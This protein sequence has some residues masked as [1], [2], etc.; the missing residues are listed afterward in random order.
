MKTE[1][2]YKNMTAH[3]ESAYLSCR[4]HVV[5]IEHLRSPWNSKSAEKRVVALFYF[6]TILLG[7]KQFISKKKK[8]SPR[9]L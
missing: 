3:L 2:T 9:Q 4:H 5:H 8:R 1:V 6:L 7:K